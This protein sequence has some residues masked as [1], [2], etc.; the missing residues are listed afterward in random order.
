MPKKRRFDFTKFQSTLPRGERPRAVL[1][2]LGRSVFQSTLPRGERHARSYPRIFASRFQSTLPRGERRFK[3]SLIVEITNFNP[4]S[5]EGS[6][7]EFWCYVK[8]FGISIHA[9]ARGATLA[10]RG[11][12][13][14]RLIS[15]HAPARG[16]TKHSRRCPIK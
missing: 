7:V 5:R 8:H 9:P 4:R 12:R 1:Q 2:F 3:T 6:D 14:Y 16:A 10:V 13:A 11:L 15:I